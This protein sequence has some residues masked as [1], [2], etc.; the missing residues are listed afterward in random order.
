[1]VALANDTVGTL[2][3][4]CY[5]EAQCYIGVI[6]GTGTNAAYI[7]RV[8]FYSFFLF[9]LF[10]LIHLFCSKPLGK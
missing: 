4:R 7:E 1:V 6:L 5:Q 10:F 8:I 9:L 2:F 3:A